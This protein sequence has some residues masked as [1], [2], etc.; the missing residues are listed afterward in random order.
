MNEKITKTTDGGIVHEMEQDGHKMTVQLTEDMILRLIAAAKA[1]DAETQEKR[2]KDKARRQLALA[3]YI[4]E[5]KQ[6]EA[7]R[8]QRQANC[9]HR[10]EN[11]QTLV[12]GQIHSDNLLHPLCLGCQ[13]EFKPYA[14][15]RELVG[16]ATGI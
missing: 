10:K 4:A 7:A 16:A 15:G 6:S 11:G 2:E 3:S 12:H 1:P 8:E 13:K 5:A 9:G 14:L